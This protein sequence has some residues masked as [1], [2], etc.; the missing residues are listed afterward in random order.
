MIAAGEVVSRPASVVKELV[1]NSLDAGADD[2]RVEI[3]NGGKRLIR[4]VDNGEGM[5]KDDIMLSLEQHA[6][7]KV[8]D[9]QDL[10]NIVTMGFRGEAVP[11]I[12]S[13]S[14]MKIASRLPEDDIGMSVYCEGGRIKKVGETGLPIGTDITVENL[15]Y[16]TPARR[17]FLKSPETELGHVVDVITQLG[18]THPQVRLDLI[19]GDKPLL[20][21]PAAETFVQ[22]IGMLLGAEAM[23][24]M[25]PVRWEADLIRITGLI[26]RPP[27]SRASMKYFFTYINRRHVRDRMVNH[28]IHESYRGRLLK[29]RYPVVALFLEMAPHHVDYNVHP[30]KLEVRFREPSAVYQ[31]ILRAV[32]EALKQ[33]A[34]GKPDSID[35]ADE[36]YQERIQSAVNR[37]SGSH[38]TG[39]QAIA[40]A[41]PNFNGKPSSIELPPI[42]NQVDL[43]LAHT[44]QAPVVELADPVARELDLRGTSQL[45]YLGQIDDTYLVCR[46]EEGLV[47][48]DQ[49]AA[50]ERILFERMR[51]KYQ[52]DR[53]PSQT[54]LFPVTI[55]LSH[56]EA[57]LLEKVLEDL[58]RMG[59]SI[60]PFGQNSF[61]LRGLPERLAEN[62]CRELILAVV[63]DLA[64][65]ER[66]GRLDDWVDDVISQVACK[67]AI[68]AGQRLDKDEVK[69][70]LHGLAGTDLMEHCPHGRPSYRV[71]TPVELERLFL[72]R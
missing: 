53:V 8:R 1:E 16:N 52:A 29:G 13:V 72:R 3:K 6:T 14:K 68:K 31:S 60:E 46:S 10:M 2:I 5:G 48:I 41:R 43:P 50:H 22:R 63:D 49:H 28:A 33:P 9:E 42:S 70:I 59:I 7:S 20:Q 40:G 38:Q 23:D 26:C 51:S 27:F 11:A 71:L 64:Q 12:A 55:E 25:I 18:I 39:A 67:A 66:S 47:L 21:M 56:R 36:S 24:N 54:L 45:V 58:D 15:F 65:V 17:K 69:E 30:A 19:N 35:R 57:V 34:D 32:G 62:A 44:M 61:V 4:V 37:Y